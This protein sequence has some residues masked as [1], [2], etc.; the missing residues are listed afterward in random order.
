MGQT[1]TSITFTGTMEFYSLVSLGTMPFWRMLAGSRRGLLRL[2]RRKDVTRVVFFSDHGRSVGR[3]AYSVNER[4][5]RQ[6]RRLRK[7]TH[8]NEMTASWTGTGSAF[9]LLSG[10]RK[11]RIAV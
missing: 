1:Q 11:L 10:A 6:M 9:K 8:V 3:A 4:K 2:N 7:Q 5:R